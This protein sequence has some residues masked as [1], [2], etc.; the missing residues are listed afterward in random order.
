MPAMAK[1]RDVVKA[2]L[3]P[4]AK[5]LFDQAVEQLGMKQQVALGRLIRW[6]TRQDQLTQVLLMGNVP[7]ADVPDFAALIVGKAEAIK[8]GQPIQMSPEQAET[9]AK[10]LQI[11]EVQRATRRREAKRERRRSASG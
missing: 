1:E 11:L 4:D 7:E 9:F 2:S 10:V 3:A 6:F 5:Q 8:K